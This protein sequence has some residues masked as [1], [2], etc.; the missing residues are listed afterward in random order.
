MLARAFAQLAAPIFV[1]Q[2]PS[3][4][5]TRLARKIERTKVLED[6]SQ[7][8]NYVGQYGHSKAGCVAGVLPHP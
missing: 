6:R 7:G 2:A 1:V 3:V 8:V 5:W 4:Q